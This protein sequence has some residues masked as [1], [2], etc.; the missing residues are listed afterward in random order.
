MMN[1][2]QY[3]PKE[4]H[5]VLIYDLHDWT[6]ITRDQQSS[7]SDKEDTEKLF[8]KVTHNL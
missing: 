8:T 5:A 3:S 6:A 2:L 7:L 4:I 1:H